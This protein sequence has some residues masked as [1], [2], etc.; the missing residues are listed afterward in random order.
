[1]SATVHALSVDVEDWYSA[2]V[3]A[4]SGQVVP[5]TEAV[6]RNTE[7]L[8]ALFAEHG[9]LATWFVLG[10]VADAFPNLVR[11]IAEAGHELGV[12]GYHHHRLFELTPETFR[13]AAR[14]AKEA[15]EQAGGQRV[16][17]HRAV[18]FSLSPVTWW[19]LEILAAL[20]FEYDSSVFP[21]RGRRYGL[22][23]APL[24]PYKIQT[25]RGAL[26]EVPLSVV[27]L[28]RLR[29]PCCGGGYLRHFPL[30]C[31]RAAL[32]RIEREARAAVVYLHPYELDLD[33]DA[34]YL[35]QRLPNVSRARLEY[36]RFLQYRRRALTAE[37]L[38]RLL[39][40]FRFGTLS[41]VMGLQPL[42]LPS[43]ET[44]A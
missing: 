30:S 32:R 31:T 4:L 9:V 29:F 2:G 42:S 40:E 19:A 7:V 22:P 21:F 6:V 16:R 25:E 3:L 36:T 15:V 33:Y 43:P 11:R 38:H 12:H 13:E 35:R 41:T 39:E 27:S 26:W 20:G 5:P 34:E 14:R 24:R 23:D 18:A 17:G 8:L 37:N 10:E 28:G 1:M 44:Y